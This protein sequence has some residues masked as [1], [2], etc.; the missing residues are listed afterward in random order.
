MPF[1]A[2][3]S[4]ILGAGGGMGAHFLFPFFPNWSFPFLLGFREILFIYLFIYGLGWGK[5]ELFFF[6]LRRWERGFFF[7]FLYIGLGLGGPFDKGVP[8]VKS[9]PALKIDKKMPQI[10]KKPLVEQLFINY[11]YSFTIW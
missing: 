11:F 1:R 4:L 9:Y 10:V 8:I 3:V 6:C 2:S 7:L 5:G